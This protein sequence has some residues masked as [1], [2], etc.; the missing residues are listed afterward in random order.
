MYRFLVKNIHSSCR[1][2]ISKSTITNF[3][4]M[5]AGIVL[6][7][8][9]I[10]LFR[11]SDFGTDPFSC[12]NLGISACLGWSFGNWQLLLNA[13][14]FG[15]VLW[16]SKSCI[17]IGTIINMTCV[18]YTADFFTTKLQLLF[19]STELLSF[20][21]RACIMLIAVILTALAVAM[22]MTAEMGI[23][24]YDAI[25]VIIEN[26]TNNKVPLRYSRV[27][28]DVLCVTIGILTGSTV[29]LGTVI[30]AFFTGPLV[31]FMKDKILLRLRIFSI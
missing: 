10:S 26:K 2:K 15:I 7:G 27:I 28:T 8:F 6:M 30:T 9:C 1:I 17:G 23:A 25:G 16:N 11:I 29:G 21:L 22:Y 5:L 13:L 20:G 19:G 18:G 14:L 24:P 12:M 31:Q 3:T 4:M